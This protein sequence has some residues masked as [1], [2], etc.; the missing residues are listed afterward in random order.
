[1][2]STS[3]ACSRL[4]KA[5]ASVRPEP[6]RMVLNSP[7]LRARASCFESALRP[8]DV[9]PPKPISYPRLPTG[10]EITP[11]ESKGIGHAK[12]DLPGRIDHVV[13][14][15]LVQVIPVADLRGR[16]Q[17]FLLIQEIR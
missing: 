17:N 6:A 8:V 4:A 16:H 1:M 12:S 9:M 13:V 5:S 3:G 2:R 10:G 15:Q 11:F 14:G 7:T